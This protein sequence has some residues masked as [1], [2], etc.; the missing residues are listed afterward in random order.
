MKQKFYIRPK[1]LF[2]TPLETPLRKPHSHFIDKNEDEN[3]QLGRRRRK[4]HAL[5]INYIWKKIPKEKEIIVQIVQYHHHP[6][7]LL[8]VS[9]HITFLIYSHHACNENRK[10]LDMKSTL[11]TSSSSHSQYSYLFWS[12]RVHIIEW[13]CYQNMLVCIHFFLPVILPSTSYFTA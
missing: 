12:P 8:W 11:R 9:L 4:R 6:S 10:N 7:I 13:D 1:I 5:M 3:T 2:L